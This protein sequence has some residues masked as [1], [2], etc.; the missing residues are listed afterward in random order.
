MNIYKTIIR[1]ALLQ[2]Y[3]E[4]AHNKAILAGKFL[5]EINNPVFEYVWDK[6]RYRNRKIA[7]KIFF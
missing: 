6:T 3:P 4:N 5:G 7:T 1:P 2:F